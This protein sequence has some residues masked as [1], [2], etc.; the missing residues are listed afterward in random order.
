MADLKRL[1]RDTTSGQSAAQPAAT[2][3]GRARRRNPLLWVGAPIVVLAA[4]F[5]W[6]ALKGR[7]PQAPAAAITITPF[8]TDGGGKFS[9][10]LSPDGEKV[11]YAWAGADDD[12]WDI[13]VKALGPGTKPLRITEDPAPEWSPTWSPD[14]RQLAFVRVSD[15]A[16]AIYVVPSLGGQ[17]RKLVDIVGP[18]SATD[19]ILPALS[20]APDGEW[21]AFVEKPSEDAP[22]RIVQL[23][24]ATLEK[25][26]LT[27][28]PPETLGD[29]EPQISPD[30]RL[31][32]FVRSGS[33][34][35]GNQ[36]VWVQPVSGG[37][38]RRLTSGQYQAVSALSWTPDGAEVVFSQGRPDYLGRIARVPLAGGAPQ[39]VT[40]VGEN[41]SHAS[42]CGHRM[43]FVQSTKTFRDIWRLARPG[44]APPTEPEKFL[45]ASQNAA[46]SPDGRKIAFESVR[47]G[48]LDIWLANAD[49]S[50]PV[51]LM[52]SK[53]ESG[54][55]RWSPDGRRLVFDSLAA[56]NWDLYVIGA[57]GGMARR[58]TE[59]PSEDGTGAWSRDGRFIYFH[60]D[61]TGRS[62]IWKIP[63]DGGTAV[64]VTRRGG[65]YAMESDDGQDLYYSKS[66]VSGVWRVP[67]AGGAE[68]EV[69]AQ[70]VV[71]QNWALARR[72]LYYA[73][74]RRQVPL[75]RQE[76]TIQ[77]LDFGSGHATPLF[78]KEGVGSHRSL[79]VSPDEK[80]ILFGQDPGWQSELMLMENFH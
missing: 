60:S 62:E 75:R 27:S 7:A 78:R 22:A 71:W 37:A 50:H 46:Y 30:G 23:S 80:W 13:Y 11:A 29:L 20:W 68:S 66:S 73:T 56:G 59:E 15:D 35:W 67:V 53:S 77:Y 31:L 14:G 17:E 74:V 76:F 19:Y 28:P 57:D 12:N 40:G 25:R 47:S 48:T 69:V 38:A 70:P 24:L 41:T 33:R 42:V 3:R 49:G 58:L 39:P 54:T 6:W 36:D 45:V 52:T 5:G 61:R 1:R 64:Q 9:P 2:A 43:V 72:G 18:A 32:A 51:Q 8:T 79:A 44:A 34:I 4:G 26:S 63:A 10:R 21:L 16:A 65:F 55:H